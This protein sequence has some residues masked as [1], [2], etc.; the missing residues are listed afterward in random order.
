MCTSQLDISF[1]FSCRIEKKTQNEVFFFHLTLYSNAWQWNHQRCVMRNTSSNISVNDQ[2]GRR[3]KGNEVFFFRNQ[4]FVI[5]IVVFLRLKT[6][7]TT[8]IS[9]ISHSR[10]QINHSFSSQRTDDHHY[11]QLSYT[12]EHYRKETDCFSHFS[13]NSLD[14]RRNLTESK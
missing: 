8:S 6:R 13:P 3:K 7:N 4:W 10:A 12:K 5:L 11:H 14:M 9:W 1:F 2:W